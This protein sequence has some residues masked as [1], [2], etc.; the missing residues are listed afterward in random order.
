MQEVKS[1]ERRPGAAAQPQE[2]KQ[3]TNE[4]THT[5]THAMYAQPGPRLLNETT[6]ASGVQSVS[7]RSTR[8]ATG[9]DRDGTGRGFSQP[10]APRVRGH[11]GGEPCPTFPFLFFSESGGQTN[12]VTMSCPRAGSQERE[13]R[14]EAAARRQNRKLGT[15]ERGDEELPTCR[16]SRA[17]TTTRS[18]RATTEKKAGDERT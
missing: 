10:R 1:G 12:E 8:K 9:H 17:R 13:R 18:G 15:N 2:R 16:K 7:A 14:P 4:R 6:G 11:L 3:G 5:H